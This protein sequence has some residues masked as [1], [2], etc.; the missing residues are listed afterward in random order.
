[1]PKP[2]SESCSQRERRSAVTHKKATRN[3]EVSGIIYLALALLLAFA[4]Y[5]PTDQTGWMGRTAITL[6]RGILGV[7]SYASPAFFLYLA[8]ESIKEKRNAIRRQRYTYTLV[9]V[10]SL[11]ALFHNFTVD[12]AVFQDLFSG[13]ERPAMEAVRALWTI[14]V[15]PELYPELGQVL[16]G[17]LIGG[18]IASALYTVGGQIGAPIMLISVVIIQIVDRKSVV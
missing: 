17:G 3:R 8:F 11:A 18:L 2:S 7:V 9:V 10:I 1:M 6:F 14:G 15:H 12:Q 5:F 16:S 13:A 4:L